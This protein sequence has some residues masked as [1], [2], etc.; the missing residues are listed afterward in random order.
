MLYL[1]LLEH[2]GSFILKSA[3]GKILCIGFSLV[4]FTYIFLE[5]DGGFIL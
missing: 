3:A 1:Y 4:V 2:D 5:H